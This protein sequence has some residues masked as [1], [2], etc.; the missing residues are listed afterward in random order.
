MF[1]CFRS[2][3]AGRLQSICSYPYCQFCIFSSQTLSMGRTPAERPAIEGF[4]L[5]RVASLPGSCLQVSKRITSSH[6]PGVHIYLHSP[7]SRYKEQQA[8]LKRS[9]GPPVTS[10]SYVQLN[11]S[12]VLPRPPKGLLKVFGRFR[13]RLTRSRIFIFF[14]LTYPWVA[15]CESMILSDP[16]YPIWVFL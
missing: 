5:Q 12:G 3:S 14:F 6:R 16:S 4:A 2:T 1:R 11:L 10:N 9:T 7:A 8:G 13:T 15:N